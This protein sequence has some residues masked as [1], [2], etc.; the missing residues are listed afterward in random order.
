VSMVS[1]TI[2]AETRS[3]ARK[4]MTANPVTMVRFINFFIL[5]PLLF[6]KL[7]EIVAGTLVVI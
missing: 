3:D 6:I 4:D 5:F 7:V 1:S 2:D